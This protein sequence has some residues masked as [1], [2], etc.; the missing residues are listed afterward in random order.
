[1]DSQRVY[2]VLIGDISGSK[3]L[4]GMDRY[5]TQLFV[6]SAIVQINEQFSSSIEAP[7]TITK[8]DEFQGL[9]DAPAHAYEMIHALQKMVFP[10]RV[11]YGIGIGSIFRMGGVLPIE[12]DGPA[13]HKA[14]KAL[15]LAKK[16]KCDI[17]YLSDNETLNQMINTIF[18]LI[19]AIKSRW[20]ER[21]FNLYWSYQALGTYREVAEMENVTPQAVCDILKNIRATD[22]IAAERNLRQIFT[23]LSMD[24]SKVS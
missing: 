9:I 12:M 2:T 10:I 7:M 5:Q 23:Q 13:F 3:Q 1:M 20:N 18:S 19:T 15:N 6:K 11:R 14:N 16:K 17:W 21:H 4:S 8:G 24:P 22:V